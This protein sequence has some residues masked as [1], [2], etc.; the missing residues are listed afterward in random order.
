MKRLI[1]KTLLITACIS[2]SFLIADRCFS[3]SGVQRITGE[4]LKELLNDPGTIIIDVRHDN[5]WEKSK[6]KI[7]G[8]VHEDPLDEEKSWAGRY[9][10]DKNI[11]LY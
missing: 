5:D 10:K 1:V 7:K 4:E 8:A 11:V 2:L 6:Q 9:P 3:S